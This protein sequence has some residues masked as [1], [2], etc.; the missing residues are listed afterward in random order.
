MAS[1]SSFVAPEIARDFA[2][3]LKAI[4][5]KYL[6]RP[7]KND[8]ISSVDEAKDWFEAYAFSQNHVVV[9]ESTPLTKLV[10]R[11][12][13]YRHKKETKNW[14]DLT[15]KERV[16][17]NTSIYQNKCLYLLYCSFRRVSGGRGRKAF[18]IGPTKED[19]NHDPMTDPFHH[20]KT[21]P[22]RPQ[23]NKTIHMAEMVRAAGQTFSSAAR[24]LSQDDLHLSQKKYYNLIR[25]GGTLTRHE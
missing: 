13:C 12:E 9:V 23:W 1:S 14:R 3:A 8:E 22:R 18:L 2:E 6:I 21:R 16:R 5:P 11:I 10:I 24:L 17:K 4:S 15:E 19:Y 20:A 7:E 25:G